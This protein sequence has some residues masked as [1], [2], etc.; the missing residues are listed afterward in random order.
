MII[1]TKIVLKNLKGEEIKNGTEV[2]TL[3]EALGNILISTKEGG[4]MKLFILGQKMVTQKSVDL[5]E[6]D[7]ALL[8]SSVKSSEV[9]NALI[10]GQCEQILESLNEKSS[11]K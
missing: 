2:F 10:L 7:L 6:S 5:D 11:K 1:N 9:Y 8:K 3:G 4:K